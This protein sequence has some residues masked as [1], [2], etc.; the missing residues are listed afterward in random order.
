MKCLM[1]PLCRI[2]VNKIAYAHRE[3]RTDMAWKKKIDPYNIE[4]LQ[5]TCIYGY[6]HFSSEMLGSTR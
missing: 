3:R 6:M 1:S 2:T 5:P 4:L